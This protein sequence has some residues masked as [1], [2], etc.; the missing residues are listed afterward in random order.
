LT[1]L[2]GPTKEPY[3]ESIEGRYLR[4]VGVECG[5][6]CAYCVAG[7]RKRQIHATAHAWP[8]R[9]LPWRRL[10]LGSTP[11][12]AI[13]L[14]PIVQT[15]QATSRL[16]TKLERT[17]ARTP[18]DVPLELTADDLLEVHGILD[19]FAL[20]VRHQRSLSAIT[21][22]LKL[23]DP[24]F[25]RACS[26]FPVH[27]TL[28]LPSANP[29]VTDALLGRSGA[30][31]TIL[32]ALQNLLRLD[33]PFGLNSIVTRDNV[34]GLATLARFVFEELR[35]TGFTLPVFYPER[36]LLDA[37]PQAI[38]LYP[39]LSRLNDQLEQIVDLCEGR[40][41]RVTVVDVPPCRL[42]DRVANSEHVQLS[43][44]SHTDS[45]AP[46]YRIPK[47]ATCPEDPDCCHF[48]ELGTT[49]RR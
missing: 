39:P 37:D 21:P 36:A 31:T 12:H 7:V 28:T 40:D 20:H 43:F 17:L 25:A 6:A 30:H 34:D 1:R 27:F 9:V 35:L 38:Q 44:V 15:P 4:I 11:V 2:R 3:L 14:E 5:L 22:G 10:G 16:L 49:P 29:Q 41:R 24:D 26:R 23:A 13:A 19:I 18:A 8:W 47:C 45:P 32:R 42:S 33:I 48:T 46:T